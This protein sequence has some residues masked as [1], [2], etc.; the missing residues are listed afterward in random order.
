MKLRSLRIGKG[1]LPTAAGALVIT[2]FA[3]TAIH[4]A[5]RAETSRRTARKANLTFN[6][7]IAPIVF[8]NCAT[9]HRAGEVAPFTLT[10]YED[11]KKRAQQIA[12]VTKT[13]YMPPWHADSHGEFRNERKLSDEQIAMLEQWA[14]DGAKRGSGPAPTPP[15]GNAGWGMGEPDLIVQ[16]AQSYTM[17]AEGVDDY[18]CFVIRNTNNED[19][20]V[21]AMEVRPGNAKVVHHVIAYL[22]NDPRVAKKEAETT[23]GQPGYTSFGGIGVTPI[24][25]LG[26]WA[27][28][29]Y[30]TRLPEGT[31]VL[32]PKGADIVL[33]VHYHASGKPETDLTRLGLHFCKKP[34]DKQLRI[35]PIFGSLNIPA[36][37]PN[38]RVKSYDFPV[39]WDA[40]VLQVMP[41]M[42]LLGKEMVITATLPN[43]D[44][45]TLVNVPRY[46]F[47]WQTTYVYKEPVKL[48][49]GS[50][51]GL[52]A[53]YD[54]STSNPANPSN[55]PRAVG[56]GEQTTDEMCIGF[57]FFTL[58][59]EFITQGKKMGAFGF[60]S[61]QAGRQKLR[62]AIG[63]LLGRRTRAATE[64]PADH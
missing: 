34:V 39:P 37:E 7:D 27:P 8:N 10:S 33:Q 59:D 47:N 3:L 19:R 16:P 41:H 63:Q 22:T 5:T 4:S 14:G 45:K 36:G 62:Q 9:C 46:D 61:D 54:N 28:G 43:G 55:P 30:P 38:Y 29:N 31:G 25:T 20:Y 50:K 44:K 35:F 21:S 53:R 48:P 58:D 42:H 26:G 13:K 2:A 64:P 6:K 12:D 51:I 49:K 52:T 56:W 15:K 40:T 11:V 1:W 24:G 17:R 23:D 18:R 57:V 32:W 60:G